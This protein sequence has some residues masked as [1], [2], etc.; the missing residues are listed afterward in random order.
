MEQNHQPVIDN[1]RKYYQWEKFISTPEYAEL[2]ISKKE[3]LRLQ[4]DDDAQYY[5]I[6]RG[7]PKE[8]ALYADTIISFWTPY[9]Y[10]LLKTTGWKAYCT[11]CSLS[12][13][14][15]QLTASHITT[16]SKNIQKISSRVSKFANLCY[17]PGNFM[18]LPDRQMNILRYKYT[19][20]R[21]DQTIYKSFNG[22]TLAR[23]FNNDDEKLKTWIIDQRLTSI[24]KDE[25]IAKD[26]IDWW[27]DREKDFSEL[28]ASE[29]LSY[30]NRAVKFIQERNHTD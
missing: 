21:L 16:Y 25:Q 11:E 2:P 29:I 12:S 24:F 10:L 9:K 23:F 19:Q 15:Y 1:I 20:D 13:L 4:Y 22:G 17:T 18:L 6:K 14:L 30:I 7:L 27:A 8:E 5:H 26:N 28:D 3:D